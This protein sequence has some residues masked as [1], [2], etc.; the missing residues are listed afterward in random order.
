MELNANSGRQGAVF[1][2]YDKLHLDR[3]PRRYTVEAGKTLTDTWNT[4]LSD[5]GKYELWVYGPNGYVRSFKGDALFHDTAAFQPEVQVGYQTHSG[6]LYLRLRNSGKQAR[7]V[8]SNA[9]F[10]DGPWTMTVKAGETETEH[11]NLE[12]SSD[13]Y[14][15]TV[16][17]DNFERRFAGRVE[18]GK[19]G[20]SDPAMA[21]HLQA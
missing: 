10:T 20:V 17:A 19:P 18:S 3:I 13:W 4:G 2:V 14:D 16:T 7:H 12:K 15:F 6:H 5:S 9:Y 11:W 21:L 8:T 1:H